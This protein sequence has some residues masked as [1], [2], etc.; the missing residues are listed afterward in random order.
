LKD[1]LETLVGHIDMHLLKK[2]VDSLGWH[3]MQ[4]KVSPTNPVW[5][6]IDVPSIRLWKT[7]LDGSL[8]LPTR[9][10]SPIP[11]RPIWGNDVSRLA[12]REKFINARLSK[13]VDFWKVGIAQ[14]LTY[15][16]NMKLYVEYWEDILLHLS[17]SLPP[18]S[19]TL[20]EGFW[21][22]NNWKS[23]YVKVLMSTVMDVTNIE[24]LV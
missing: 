19:V 21:P 1:G 5:S 4:Y 2:I 20:L 22:S 12:E 7:N 16:M 8:K 23:N 17:R 18:Q 14:N 9:V 10:P 6:P 15:E 3:V 13:Y 24:D 11:Y